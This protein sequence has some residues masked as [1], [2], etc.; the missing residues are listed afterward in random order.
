MGVAHEF[1]GRKKDQA[2]CIAATSI[3]LDPSF[4]DFGNQL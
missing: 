2:F 1:N 3:D 4:S